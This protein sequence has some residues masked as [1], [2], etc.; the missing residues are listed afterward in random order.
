MIKEDI[1]D[2]NIT[3]VDNEIM[4]QLSFT[5]KNDRFI[6]EGFEFKG[7]IQKNI[8]ETIKLLKGATGTK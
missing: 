7:S 8:K 6:N 5:V 3:F 4:N 1:P 2:L